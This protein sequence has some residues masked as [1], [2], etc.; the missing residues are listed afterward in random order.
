MDKYYRVPRSSEKD[1]EPNEIRVGFSN[2]VNVS[3]EAGLNLLKD[4]GQDTIIIKALGSKVA[5]AIFVAEIIKLRVLGLH[6]ITEIG[7]TNIVT[8][9]LPKEEGLDKVQLTKQTAFVKIT[10]STKTLDT[11]NPGYQPPLP[12]DKVN[13]RE[14]VPPQQYQHHQQSTSTTTTATTS[15]PSSDTTPTTTSTTTARYS[16]RGRGRGR[17]FRGRG[18]GFRGRGRGRGGFSSRFNGG[19]PANTT[20]TPSP[21]TAN[22]TTPG[23]TPETTSTT[24][25]QE[26]NTTGV[27]NIRSFRGRGRGRGSGFRGRGRGGGFRGSFRGRGRGGFRSNSVTPGENGEEGTFVET[28][29][30]PTSNTSPKEGGINTAT[31]PT[32]TSPSSYRGGYRGRGRGGFRGGRG[33][34]SF[35]GRG[36]GGFFNSSQPSSTITTQ[37]DS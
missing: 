15:S 2:K 22:T 1:A 30:S 14:S 27:N 12:E 7:T 3:V 17:G 9:Y 36:R 24:T 26:E 28:T 21:V 31:N 37:N 33:R 11:T 10:L 13:P 35:R 18:R 25:T 6:Q 8:E 23:Q 16:F 32:G 29:T 19:L 34:G 5:K 20:I 4:K